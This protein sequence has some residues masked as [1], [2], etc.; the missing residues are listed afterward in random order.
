MSEHAPVTEGGTAPLM[1]LV[2]EWCD[3][4]PPECT[5]PP[6][7]ETMDSHF[8][9]ANCPRYAW[10]RKNFQCCTA[11]QRKCAFELEAALKAWAEHLNLEAR[12]DTPWWS[13]E[14]I[15]QRVLGR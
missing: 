7:D 12:L 8:H 14:E 10:N 9:K 2:R 4:V 5:C 3:E 6:V 1:A 11:T 15:T 13:P